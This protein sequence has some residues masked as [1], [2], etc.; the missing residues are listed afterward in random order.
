M[1]ALVAVPLAGAAIAFLMRRRFAL[2][3]PVVAA[4]AMLGC[5]LALLAG[6]EGGE[7]IRHR[8]GGWAPP[9]GIAW[10]LDGL[11]ALLIAV[12]SGVAL[13]VAGFAAVAMPHALAR[14]YAPPFL[15]LLAGLTALFLSSDVF[16][17]YVTLELT[18]LSAV[19]LAA[20]TGGGPAL[21]AAFRYLIVAQA[22]SLSYLLGVGF[23]YTGFGT[24]DIDQLGAAI[25]PGLPA[26]V[27]FALMTTGLFAKAA[28]FPLHGWMPALQG[29]VAAPVAA[30]M[31]AV[32]ELSFFYVLLRL[33]FAVFPAVATPGI[34]LMLAGLG[35]AA[36]AWGSLAALR[37]P[38]LRLLVAY[39]TVAQY[40]YLMLLLPLGMT[41]AAPLAWTGA[42]VLAASHAF[43]KAGMF[44]SAG[45]VLAEGRG[46]GLAVL[47]GAGR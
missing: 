26:A 22:G 10:R 9:L 3:V 21:T 43:A 31:S 16:N 5:V 41:E 20:M 38:R 44:L 14:R 36:V 11:S 19:A 39:S 17:L 7:T 46:D 6:L 45:A 35:A 37:Q 25:E 4:A 30:M 32:V 47:T 34:A 27:G 40:G 28:L 12:A 42:L 33:W 15:L 2:W 1:A 24:L 13:G 23:L 29:T 8:L 18:S